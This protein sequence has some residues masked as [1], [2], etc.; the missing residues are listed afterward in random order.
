MLA[1]RSFFYM[2]LKFPV[3]LWV[4][5]R[6]V[7]DKVLETQ[8]G[9]R[10]KPIFY[11][12]RHQSASDLLTLQ[13]AC[14][15]L[16]FPDPL[17]TITIDGKTFQ[18]T[19]CLE[20]PSQVL[21]SKGAIKGK[22]KEQGLALLALHK[23]NPQLDV[24]LIP[25]NLVWGRK[26]TIEKNNANV[27][28][29]LADQESPSWLRKFF[30]V[31]F[32]GR[33]T[34]VRF[35]Q[36]LSLRYMA[37]KHGTDDAIARKLLRVARFHF[38]RQKI[39]ATG[40]RLMH[41]QQMF[42][43]LMKNP[44]IKKLIQDEVES[45]GQS[46]AVAKKHALKIMDEIA[47]DYRESMVRVGER[48]L[49]WLW[50][51]LYQGIEVN[52]ANTLRELADDGHEIIYVPCH[53]SHMDYLLLTYIIYQQGLVTPRI[54]AGINLN[55]WPAGPIFRK[56]G[57]FFIRRSF[58]GN[59]M[60]STIFREYLGLLFER[61][62]SVK[63]Y[64]EG[65]RSR[66][67]RLLDPKTGMLA[68]TI[69]SLLRGIN[70]PLTLVPVYLGYE[71]V[72]E[73]GT[74]H[75]EL[76][77]SKKKNESVF[78]VFKAIKNLR[79]YGKGFVN[80]GTPININ[81]FLTEQVPNW[82]D[83]IDA[84]DPQ[85]PSWLTPSVNV[86][87]DQVMV[88]INKCA[89]LNGVSLIALIL[90]ATKN[91]ALSRQELII[92]LDFFLAI[93][94]Q[95][96]YSDELTLPEQNGEQLL[97]DAITLNKVTVDQ[98]SFGDII[99]LSESAALEMRYYRN[100]IL[101]AFMLP[102]L[103]CRILE[104]NAKIAQQELEKQVQHILVLLKRD[105]FLWQSC[106]EISRQVS[107]V[108]AT[109][110]SLNT[111][112]QSKAGFWSLINENKTLSSINLLGECAD[113]TLQRL[114]IISIL[115]NRLSPINKNDFV[116]KVVAIAKRLTV[117]NSINA[118]E[119]IDKKTQMTLI[120]AMRDEGLIQTDEDGLL[121]ANSTL[122]ITRSYVTNLVDISVLQSILR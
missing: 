114:T 54:A 61:G 115:I 105:L 51:R 101:H 25:A 31:L 2:L 6:I 63:Y 97:N 93:Q 106:D 48:V 23:N 111:A 89:A 49:H 81:Q 83:D 109:L 95:A 118:A 92:Q 64:S 30:I 12:V 56:A 71:H 85:K 45:K 52:N 33:N 59:R 26:P 70:R 35:S 62:Y 90:L 20:K 120:D 121:M 94:K 67:G 38:H 110:A 76:S 13:K 55:F 98:D 46:E 16:N 88:A 80:F 19:L 75:K 17:E 100:N 1:L 74:Y 44:S 113:E 77:G 122:D 108:L 53:R 41:R 96:P 107:Q 40:P 87:A 36:S 104:K 69:Q 29:I 103:V 112:K 78:G 5:C 43:A 3:Q 15:K 11:I 102:A 47:G 18:R 8:Q 42:K 82:K 34:L 117:L 24:Q 10:N 27:G 84:I 65:G 91:K 57:A 99:S 14:K 119:F 60:Y 66:T 37:D 7:A 4:K 28:T 72:M 21:F 79:N 68:M 32:L 39:A 50:N 116:E 86:L 58:R 22:A 9:N 73:V